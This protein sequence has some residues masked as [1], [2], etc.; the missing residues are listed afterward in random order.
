MNLIE[1]LLAALEQARKDVGFPDALAEG[2]LE[3]TSCYE[4]NPGQRQQLEELVVSLQNFEA[5][6]D[7]GCFC[8]GASVSRIERLVQSVRGR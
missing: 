7:A 3:L 5:C 6:A 2:I 1:A 4:R 8:I